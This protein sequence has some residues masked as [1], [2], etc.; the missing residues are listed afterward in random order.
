MNFQEIKDWWPIIIAALAFAAWLFRLE[1]RATGNTK[2][3][4]ENAAEM[5]KMETRWE[6]RRAEDEAR[7]EKQR[8]EDM[9]SR[10]R[11]WDQMSN[12]LR[13]MRADIKT[14]LQRD[15]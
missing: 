7:R 13:E 5:V 10:Q 1:Y 11:D 14:L 2:G 9:A 3:I 4:A 8:A 12:T 6:K 15:K